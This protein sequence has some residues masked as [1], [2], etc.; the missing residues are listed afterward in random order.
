[1]SG[2][3]YCMVFLLGAAAGAAL[4][5]IYAPQSGDKTRKQLKRNLNNAGKYVRQSTEEV[6]EQAFRVY[7]KAKNVADDLASRAGSAAASVTD[8]V[9]DLV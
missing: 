5:L 9:T 3:R 6:S 7:K 8:K 2:K 1:M 4:A